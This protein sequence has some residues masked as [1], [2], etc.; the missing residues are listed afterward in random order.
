MINLPPGSAKSTYGSKLFP[1]WFL[2]QR[3]RLN[4]IGASNTASLAE[5]FSRA[6]MG[7]VRDHPT[8]L[9][10]S[11]VRESAELWT[12]SNGG[13]YRAA[14]VGG[15]IAGRRADGVIIDDPTRSREDADSETIREK[16]W[17]WFMS[18]LRTRLKPNA[19][20]IVIM[21]RWH[22]DDLGGRLLDRQPGLWRVISL[23]AIAGESDALGRQPGEWLWGDDTYGY[24]GALKEA[25]EEFDKAGAARDWAA[26]YQQEPVLASGAVFKTDRIKLI[27]PDDPALNGARVARGWDLAATEQIGTRNPDY[28]AGVKL[29]RMLDGRFVVMDVRRVRKGPEDTEALITTTADL[30]GRSVRVGLPQDPG[31]AGKTQVLYLTKKLAGY[32]IEATPET[33]DKTVRATPCASQCNVGNL[34]MVRGEWNHA[35]LDELTSFPGGM[36]DDQVD[37]LSR[38]FSMVGMTKPMAITP[39]GRARGRMGASR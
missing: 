31:Q 2:A 4:I 21:T 30:D 39:S 5:D 11:L 29:A 16:Q 18:D 12:T 19:F 35:F 24:A 3:E 20:I 25:Y 14:G 26:L 22:P 27:E 7:Y 13:Q 36:K 23:P 17:N 37:A 28:T 10:Y 38:A 32:M 15:A 8:E 34:Y 1:P 9:G 6:C 33:G